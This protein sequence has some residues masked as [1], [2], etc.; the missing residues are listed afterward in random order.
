[1]ASVNLL[2]VDDEASFVE[3]MSRRLLQRGFAVATACSAEEAL[4]R[5][6]EDKA[7]DVVVLDVRMPG[8]DGIEAVRRIKER[9]PLIEVVM[10]TGHA[11]LDS[12]IEAIKRGAFGYLMKPCHMED[13]MT[14]VD[15]AVGRKR[16]REARILEVQMKPYISDRERDQLI[17][18]VLNS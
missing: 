10:L 18:E 2:L 4:K 9:H 8:M 17:S 13:L 6:Q 11:T 3:V 12:A 5:L 16:I 7:T 1:M 14:K 15:E